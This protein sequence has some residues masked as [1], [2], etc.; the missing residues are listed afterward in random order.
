MPPAPTRRPATRCGEP[1]SPARDASDPS[2]SGAPCGTGPAGAGDRGPCRRKAARR[3]RRTCDRYPARAELRQETLRQTSGRTSARA[4]VPAKRADRRSICRRPT[5]GEGWP[6]L[7]RPPGRIRARRRSELEI[8]LG[9][10]LARRHVEAAVVDRAASGYRSLVLHEEHEPAGRRRQRRFPV[11]VRIEQHRARAVRA[12]TD[13]ELAF[14][15]VPDLREVVLVQR[16]VRA[17]LIAHEPGI[18]LCRT[19]GPWMEEHLAPLAGPAQRLPC[20]FVDVDGF[21]WKMT[22]RHGVA[23]G[24]CLLARV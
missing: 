14:K 8:L 16:M 23:H 20:P 11:R 17:G 10:G 4:I 6:G 3:R 2:S 18:G 21:H 15:D 22:G 1:I 9:D 12:L 24:M 13:L 5:T 7:P 19:L